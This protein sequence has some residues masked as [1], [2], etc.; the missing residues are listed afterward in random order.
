MS[1]RLFVISAPSGAGK[2]SLVKALAEQDDSVRIS[3]SSTTR[4]P[5]TGEVDGVDY[6][7][8]DSATFRSQVERGEFLEH[9]EVFGKLYGTHRDQVDG[10]LADDCDVVLE[11]DWQGAAQVCAA[12]PESVSVFILPPSREELERRLRGR[13]SDDEAEIERRLAEARAEISHWAEFRHL[14]V[15]DDFEGALAT[16]SGLVREGSDPPR[17]A[18]ASAVAEA[19]LG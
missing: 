1:G 9:A 11:I 8:I 19:L 6:V 15:N 4:Q 14:I 7:F 16:L 3:I 17:D 13:G 5:R 18:A 12:R 10:L 2:T